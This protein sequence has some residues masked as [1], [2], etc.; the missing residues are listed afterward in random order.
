MKC[1]STALTAVLFV[2]ASTAQ[3]GVIIG[4]TRLIYDGAKKESS[5]SVN[6]PDKVPYLIQSWV[7]I[8]DGGAEK[9]PL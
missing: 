3:A 2:T 6:N 8:T 4:G 1:L 7:D 5:L 9:A